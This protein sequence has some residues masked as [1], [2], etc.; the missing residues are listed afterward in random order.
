[1]YSGTWRDYLST[2]SRLHYVL[3]SSHVWQGGGRTPL[4]PGVAAAAL[5][6]VAVFA[7]VRRDRIVRIWSAIALSAFLMSFGT[8]MPG[9]EFL[10][11]VFPLL[12][13]IRAPVRAGHLVLIA[14]AALAGFG[15][16]ELRRRV[17]RLR[18]P[19][20]AG[21]LILLVT[22]ETLV[23]PLPL[24]PATPPPA[25]YGVLAG[26]PRA[27]IA[28][29]PLAPPSAPQHNAVYMV[30]STLHWRPLL[31]GYSGFVPASYAHHVERL[32]AFPA[33]EALAYLEEIG[34]THVVLEGGAF[35]AIPALE[36]V[37][38]QGGV[39]IFRVR[40]DRIDSEAYGR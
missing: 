1:M 37:A 20:V 22:V 8:S 30:A 13:G 34:V 29:L 39:G 16:A 3:W 7:L 21:G 26:E 4:F 6:A 10:Y 32:R 28:H 23:A 38:V 15:L 12:R 11:R 18:H 35:P 36:P 31:N 9:Y 2:P 5:A 14:V 25:I 33:P 24:F 17:P 27:V 40:W 19:A